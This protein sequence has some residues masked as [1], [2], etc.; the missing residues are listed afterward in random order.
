MHCMRIYDFVKGTEITLPTAPCHPEPEA[1]NEH[2]LWSI[3]RPDETTAALVRRHERFLYQR[4]PGNL[5][6]SL[7]GVEPITAPIS[8]GQPLRALPFVAARYAAVSGSR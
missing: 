8:P 4:Q 5:R 3:V 2:V 1:D 7:V 6:A